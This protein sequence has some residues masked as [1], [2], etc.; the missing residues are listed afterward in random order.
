MVNGNSRD[1]QTWWERGRGSLA[2]VSVKKHRCSAGL[3]LEKPQ[4]LCSSAKVP[5]PFLARK[6]RDKSAGGGGGR[7]GAVCRSAALGLPECAPSQ[8]LLLLPQNESG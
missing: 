1:A 3:G 2:V 5:V 7:H 6:G 8:N 4:L